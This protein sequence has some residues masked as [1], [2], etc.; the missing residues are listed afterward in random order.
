MPI[1]MVMKKII[2][3]ALTAVLLSAACKAKNEN[4]EEQ[5]AKDKVSEEKRR[6]DSVLEYYKRK[7]DSAPDSL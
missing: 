4:S 3:L 7:A 2:L 5:K 1:F 6:G